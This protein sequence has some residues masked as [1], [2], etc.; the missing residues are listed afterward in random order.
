MGRNFSLN[1]KNVLIGL[2]GES[3]ALPGSVTVFRRTA[4]TLAAGVALGLAGIAE[5]EITTGQ[6]TVIQLILLVGASIAFG[7]AVPTEC[8]QLTPQASGAESRSQYRLRA[9]RMAL[10]PSG[11]TLALSLFLF[12]QDRQRGTAFILWLVAMIWFVTS[13]LP[14]V[15]QS[16]NRFRRAEFSISGTF[17]IAALVVLL[18][19]AI[20]NFW[21]LGSIPYGL[22]WDEANF[23]LYAQQILHHT[24]DFPLLA[25][26]GDPSLEFYLHAVEQQLFGAT[27]FS[28]RVLVALS[29]I[30]GVALL[31]VFAAL[32]WNRWIALTSMVVLGF[33]RWHI[34]FSRFGIHEMTF[35]AFELGVIVSLIAGFKQRKP[36]WF[37]LCGVLLG[38]SIH[39]YSPGFALT[40]LVI[41]ALVYGLFFLRPKLNISLVV[42]TCVGF[43]LAY[44]PLLEAGLQDPA[45]F[46]ARANQVSVFGPNN[47]YP[48]LQALEHNIRAHVLMF[49]VEGDHNGRHNIPGQPQLDDVSAVLFV[50]GVAWVAIRARR[51]EYAFL[52][53]WFLAM[54][55]P[56]VLSLDFEAPQSGRAAGAQPVVAIF[57]TLALCGA[58]TLLGRAVDGVKPRVRGFRALPVVLVLAVLTYL[59][60]SNVQAYFDAEVHNESVWEVWASDATFVGKELAT[61]PP[62]ELTYI[63]PELSGHPDIAYLAPGH[64]TGAPLNPAHDLP[65]AAQ[66]PI[67]VFLTRHDYY[68]VSLLKAYYP[69]ADFRVLQGPEITTPP[70]AYGVLLSKSVLNRVRGLR[71]QYE[72]A[73]P[74]ISYARAGTRISPPR[75]NRAWNG[76]LDRWGAHRQLR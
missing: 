46:N 13:Y 51:P 70:L 67:G 53:F 69:K 60:V 14:S 33:M 40:V 36:G 61:L 52:I 4:R 17:W 26:F 16:L 30:A 59:S 49:N 7:L 5:H 6:Q 65:F 56:G 8:L 37:A 72:G 32:V 57:I 12:W 9:D 24:I 20:V 54:M 47:Q 68:Y 39:I 21:E 35:Q 22:W 63:S 64:A 2:D 50:L 71:F 75:S 44:A 73:G 27:E 29:G 38:L 18:S 43:V 34:D 74:P 19:V 15:R 1:L 66:G 41:L 55:A 3:D 42:L 28:T 10:I 45:L 48:P 76:D 25:P 62:S 11:C 58:V 23:G 31:G